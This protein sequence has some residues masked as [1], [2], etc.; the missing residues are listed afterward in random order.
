MIIVDNYRCIADKY[1]ARTSVLLLLTGHHVYVAHRAEAKSFQRRLS[2]DTFLQRRSSPFSNVPHQLFLGALCSVCL[3]VS[4]AFK[5]LA[6]LLLPF[7]SA[8]PIHLHL[9]LVTRLRICL[10]CFRRSSLDRA[11]TARINLSS[12]HFCNKAID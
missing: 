12:R 4:S 2:L 1:G 8:C 9:L 3:K 10:V 7:C 5:I 6:M 11:P